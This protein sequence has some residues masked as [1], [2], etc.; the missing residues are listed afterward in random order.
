MYNDNE[1]V[2]CPVCDKIGLT[3]PDLW[4]KVQFFH[5]VSSPRLEGYFSFSE[6]HGVLA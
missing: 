1:L 2:T 4:G 5:K 3:A 6:E